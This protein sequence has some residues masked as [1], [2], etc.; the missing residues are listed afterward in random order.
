[1]EIGE[2][3]ESEPSEDASKIVVHVKTKTKSELE[4]SSHGA[5]AIA[6]CK[7]TEDE[8]RSRARSPAHS[9]VEASIVE[10]GQRD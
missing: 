7:K 10:I 3:R 6:R 5:M 9:S 2:I 4:R 8:P 1:M